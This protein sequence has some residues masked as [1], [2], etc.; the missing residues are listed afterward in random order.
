M[1]DSSVSMHCCPWEHRLVCPDSLIFSEKVGNPQFKEE[2]LVFIMH[3][4]L[5]TFLRN[6]IQTNR[7][8]EAGVAS[9]VTSDLTQCL[10]HM[11]LK[12]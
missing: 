1:T 2:S 8:F 5:R 11:H 4:Q 9:L 7:E 10:L 3:W 12:W 6:T